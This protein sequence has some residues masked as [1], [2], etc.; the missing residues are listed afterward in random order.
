[1]A[2]FLTA[3][4]ADNVQFL[5]TNVKKFL[6]V[7]GRRTRV[8]RDAARIATGRGGKSAACVL[9]AVC[10]LSRRLSALQPLLR[11]FDLRPRRRTPEV[12][13]AFPD[14]GCQPTAVGGKDHK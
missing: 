2:S 6:G 11:C 3:P 12:E 9:A 5:P 7:T 14:A 10:P 4:F 8:T 13:L 1:M